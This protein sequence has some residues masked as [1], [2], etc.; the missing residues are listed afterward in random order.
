MFLKRRIGLALKLAVSIVLIAVV[1]RNIDGRSVI[2]RFAGE[3]NDWLFVAA[4]VTLAQILLASFRW[5]QVLEGLDVRVPAETV[6]KTTFIGSFFNAWLLG[7]FGGDIARALLVPAPIRGRS[8]VVHSVLFD[9]AVTLAGL[10]LVIIPIV[11]LDLGPLSRGLPLLVSLVV[12]LSPCVLL[13]CVSPMAGIADRWGLPFSHHIGR[14][15]TDWVQLLH[16]WQ[17]LAAALAFSALGVVA[18]SVTAYCLARAAHLDVSLLDFL[19]LM[20]P[21]MLLSALPISLGGWGV[22][23]SAMVI[24]LGS[25]GVAAAPAVVV[26]VQMGLLA[27]LLSLPGGAMWLFRYLGRQRQAAAAAR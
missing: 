24:A 9:R 19:I 7:V 17:R 27:A 3:S 15:G 12:A 16:A 13:C 14:V 21:V 23:E 25:V 1:C 22:R 18:V 8:T 20:A 10:A 5:H 2:E 6:V 11:V 4:L 26:S